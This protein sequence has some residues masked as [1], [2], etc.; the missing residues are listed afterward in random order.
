MFLVHQVGDRYYYEIPKSQLEKDFLWNLQIAKTTAGAGYGGQQITERVVAWTL[1]SNRVY[2]KDMNYSMAADPSSP[3]AK[4]VKNAN[5]DTIIQAFNVAAYN[6]DGDPVIEV[7]RLFNTDVPEF[8]AR[9]RIGAST[10]DASRSFIDHFS[11]FPENIETETTM[12]YSRAAGGQAA[13]GGGRG[14]GLGTGNM[15]GTSA[16]VVLHH[17]MVKLP[18]HPMMPRL[19]DER[20][21]Y[22]TTS[23]EDFTRDE[24]RVQQV[25]HP[26]GGVRE[27]GPER[28]ALRV[29]HRRS[30]IT[31]TRRR[32]EKMGPGG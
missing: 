22:F 19:F 14:G 26:R 2:L 15:R 13:G 18:E 27:E 16:T 4:A 6:K 5:N 31:S 20:V 25:R 21:G 32:L 9:T 1:R 8:S 28:G 3:I 10:F 24:Y 12:T 17:S 7:S 30:S 29:G 11:A 23:Q